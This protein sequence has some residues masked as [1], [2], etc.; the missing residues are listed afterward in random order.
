MELYRSVLLYRNLP[1]PVLFSRDR[2]SG[3]KM[4]TEQADTDRSNRC[5]RSYGSAYQH[6]T[7]IDR[8]V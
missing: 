2:R 4:E 5:N 3:Q 7:Y 1:G 6:E 8:T